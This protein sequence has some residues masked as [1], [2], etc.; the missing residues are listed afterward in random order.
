MQKILGLSL[1]MI[2]AAASCLALAVST[3]EIDPTS[4]SAAVALLAG[5]LLVIQHRRKK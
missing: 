5:G 3:P 2:G 4:A 1:L